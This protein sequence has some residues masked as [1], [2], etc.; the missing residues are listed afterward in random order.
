MFSDVLISSAITAH[1]FRSRTG[2]KQ[3]DK[4]LT[5]LIVWVD[6]SVHEAWAEAQA[7]RAE[8]YPPNHLVCL[9]SAPMVLD[10]LMG[11]ALGFMIVSF[12]DAH[13]FNLFWMCVRLSQT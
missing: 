8:L 1:L 10:S 7:V 13:S 3:T 6:F 11:S 4:L 5:K 12:T 9:S 2:W